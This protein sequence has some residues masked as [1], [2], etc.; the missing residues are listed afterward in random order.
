MAVNHIRFNGILLEIE[1]TIARQQASQ[2]VTKSNEAIT[3]ATSAQSTANRANETAT[4]A[5]QTASEAVQTAKS[6]ENRVNDLAGV[7]DTLPSWSYSNKTL[8]LS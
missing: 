3:K 1:D 5:S 6:V 7:I 2:A 4:Q 8:I